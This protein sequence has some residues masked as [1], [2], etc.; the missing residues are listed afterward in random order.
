MLMLQHKHIVS[1]YEVLE[2]EDNVFFVM[3]LC[4][5]G[6]LYE[7]MGNKPLSEDTARYYFSQ[8]IEG[9]S[10]S[11]AMGVV[12]RDLKLDNLLLDNNA[13]IKITDFG[14]AGIFQKGW[15]LF[16]TP[17][18][19]G[20]CH[21]APEQLLGQPYSGEKN[22]IWGL[23]VIL[24]IL[25]VGALPFKG[26]AYLDNIRNGR[27]TI[28]EHLSPEVR[29]LISSMLV[30]DPSGRI[31]CKKI[32]KHPWLTMGKKDSPNLDRFQLPIQPEKAVWNLP[33]GKICA[34]C[35]VLRDLE[36]VT[37]HLN[38]KPEA[39]K[40]K[41]RCH[42][43]EKELKFYFKLK[44]DP[45]T[46][47]RFFRFKLAEG[48][49]R[50]FLGIMPKIRMAIEDA[51]RNLQ[52]GTAT[53]KNTIQMRLGTKKATKKNLEADKETNKDDKEKASSKRDTEDKDEKD[54]KDRK[55]SK[56][57]LHEKEDKDNHDREIKDKKDS[58]RTLD[59]KH[60][61]DR[62]S[63]AA[64]EVR[65]SKTI[66]RTD[67]DK[68]HHDRE[69]QSEKISKRATM[70]E[71]LLDKSRE[72]E[73]LKE[74]HE[75]KP[76]ST[77]ISKKSDHENG[78]GTN[79]KRAMERSREIERPKDKQRDEELRGS[80]SDK[81]RRRKTKRASKRSISSESSESAHSTS[82]SIGS[83]SSSRRDGD[84]D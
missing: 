25:L 48:E 22:D 45:Q 69:V 63:E 52:S 77:V 46:N 70:D 47:E 83:S 74:I 7:Y 75:D 82:E 36:I 12:H 76:M 61:K 30:T 41:I 33:G 14:H 1:L 18:V 66:L 57:N 24:Y 39:E 56:K 34:L 27:Y 54:T 59:S 37:L 78:N 13:N 5:G 23:G 50:D 32:E 68:D 9:V 55:E 80:K 60:D 10:Y 44:R 11:H 35:N 72:L 6:S 38:D 16:C 19:G 28:P 17:T 20:L 79:G 67:K 65:G 73:K 3:E 43:P 26:Q 42:Y 81:P 51:E 84:R 62:D 53:S 29:D 8:I 58:R 2:S 64:D 21:V 71:R 31:G 4:G 40:D 15:D 49:S